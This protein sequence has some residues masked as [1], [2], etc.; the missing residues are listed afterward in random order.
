MQSELGYSVYWYI[1][2]IANIN[3]AFYIKA[4]VAAA[5]AAAAAARRLLGVFGDQIC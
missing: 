2:I 5:A 1:G 3:F 4:A